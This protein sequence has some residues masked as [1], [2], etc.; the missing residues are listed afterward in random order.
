MTHPKQ[1]VLDTNVLLEDPRALEKLRNGN[2]NSIFIPYH[3]LLELDKL[4]KDPRLGPIVA[5][6][7][8]RLSDSPESYTLLKSDGLADSFSNQVDTHILD[9][10]EKSGITDPILVTND[11]IFQL[12]ARLRGIRSEIY[13]DSKPFLSENGQYTGFVQDTEEIR[14][15]CFMWNERNQPVFF[16][17]EGRKVIG[18]Q[19]KVWNVVPRNLYQNLA[20]ELMVH[21]DLPIVSI[22]SEAGYGKS[23]LALAVALYLVLERKAQEK[24]FVVKPMIEIGRKMGY[25]PG[26]LS[27]KM[28]PYL[29]YISDL[30]L[31]LHQLRPAN[32]IFADTGSYPVQFNPRRLELLPLAYIRG[33]NIENAVVIID[34]MQN[35]SR[36]ECR[37]LLSRMGEGV[38]CIC[39]GDT[40]Q[41][42]NPYL[43]GENNGLNWVVNKFTGSRI[44]GHLLLKGDKSRGPITDL[45]IKSG[46]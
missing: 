44:Y 11:R 35:M 7:I 14:P 40:R 20:L 23:F 43:D 12:Q 34:E 3:V 29:R 16:G 31:K 37:A 24:I 21:P 22:Q 42:D 26:K 6:I 32:R 33:M 8:H 19:H 41:V 38:K 45:V 27:E 46:L 5:R 10:I 30:V 4:K 2:E 36:N 1:Y 28:E 15:N 17:P 18:Y 39:L 25:L 13:R 9:E